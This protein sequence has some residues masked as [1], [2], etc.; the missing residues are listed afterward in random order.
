MTDHKAEAEGLAER[1]SKSPH[2]GSYE[3]ANDT[4]TLLAAQVHA[5]LYL[6][7]QQR[8]ANLIAWKENINAFQRAD[9]VLDT[10][11]VGYLNKATDQIIEGLGL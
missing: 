4:E 6:A 8:I 5:T 3:F 9:Y 10:E 7:E 2:D 11:T 1:G